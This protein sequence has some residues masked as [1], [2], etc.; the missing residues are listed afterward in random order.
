MKVL[1]INPAWPRAGAGR[2]RYQRAWPPLDLLNAAALLRAGGHEVDLIDARADK[3]PH[4]EMIRRAEEADLVLFSTSPLD[5]WQCPDLDWKA[6]SGMIAGLPQARLVIA[7]AHGTV[8]PELLLHGLGAQAVI[9]GAPELV[10]ADLADAGGRP[11]G[12]SGLTWR[13][14][15][16]EAVHEP[17]RP[18]P[19]L[20][21]LPPP[22]YDLI[23]FAHYRYE[24]LG[25]RLAV[26][27][28]SRGCPHACTFCFKAV[29]GPGISYKSVDRV[30]AEAA[31][32]QARGARSVYFIDLEFTLKRQRT[33]DLCRGL[34]RGG[35]DLKWCCQTRVDAVDEELLMEMAA[36]GCRLVHFGLE[37]AD[38]ELLK[39]S[40][41]G[42]TLGQAQAA[43]EAC[44]RAGIAT[45]GFF[46]MGLPGE[47]PAHRRAV[48]ALAREL[49]PTFASFH[50]TASYNLAGPDA[51]PFAPCL[52]EHDLNDLARAARRAW[53]M[54]YLRPQSITNRLFTGGPAGLKDRVKLFLNVIR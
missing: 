8:A 50:P 1:L 40:G 27:E 41:K 4:R 15:A 36:A 25:D 23:D 34:R 42:V 39:T 45:A 5:R 9:R 28:T 35:F 2:R 46:L 51:E 38:P 54:F 31:M 48:R 7:G 6:V 30:L 52:A 16:G 14:E 53:L 49:N 11:A 37:T 44:R 47:T 33:L 22:A 19:V 32:V 21:R 26:L 3:T 13:S 20:G 10:L 24:L 29:Y 12:I 18:A 43:L 17:D